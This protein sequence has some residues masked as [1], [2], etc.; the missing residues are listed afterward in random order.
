MKIDFEKVCYD[1]EH[2]FLLFKSTP[3]K[4][5]LARVLDF[6]G[7][8]RFCDT[9]ENIEQIVKGSCTTFEYL[10]TKDEFDLYETDRESFIKLIDTL[11]IGAPSD[12]TLKVF[13]QATPQS[14][15]VTLK[16]KLGNPTGTEPDLLKEMQ[17]ELRA[18]SVESLDEFKKF[19]AGEKELDVYFVHS[20]HLN[21]IFPAI[22]FEGKIFFVEGEDN[23]KGLIEAT[24]IFDNNY[25]KVDSQQVTE[26]LKNC[27]K[28]G[29]FKV[30]YCKNDGKAYVFDRDELLGEPTEDKWSTYNSP[31]YNAFIRCIECAGINNPQVK[32]N[33]MTLTSQLSHQIYKTTFLLPLTKQAEQQPNTIVL[34]KAGEKLYNEKKFVFYGAEEYDYVAMEGNEFVAAT[35]SNSNNKTRAL[36]LFT[37]LE[38]FNRIFK[39]KVVPIAVTLDEAFSMLNDVC[40]VII[41]NPATLGFLFAEDAMKQMKE[42]S[43]KPPTVFRPKE[44][45]PKEKQTT[46]E[47]PPMPRQASTEDILH[48]VANQI[49]RDE[50]VKKEQATIAK[51]A[52]EEET[53]DVSDIEVTEP[54]EE[55]AEPVEAETEV[56]EEVAEPTEDT[57]DTEDTTQ[58]VVEEV[59]EKKE[60]TE[61]KGGFF[62]RFKKKK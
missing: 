19:L 32:A 27:K 36:P 48:M 37:D 9:I 42:F 43:E 54:E 12:R 16:A 30:A 58:E 46:M 34:S 8:L 24:K 35:L 60:P 6:D 26:I 59:T 40:K 41:F 55:V 25:Y 51:K 61:K 21:K 56:A 31:V 3:E 39:G 1:E 45:E 23:V 50:A 2:R 20:S 44:E 15:P 4:Y 22:D 5:Y 7:G 52:D 62:S 53:E 38:E 28:Y 47:I 13:T 33:Q 11:C 57:E 14:K 29:V 18:E 10:I 49:N 17:T